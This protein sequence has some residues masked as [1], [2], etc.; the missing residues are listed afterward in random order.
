MEE[1][2]TLEKYARRVQED[3]ETALAEDPM[4]QEK[5]VMLAHIL[6]TAIKELD[7]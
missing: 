5:V 1:Q 7:V 2:D 6:K 4:N 3:L